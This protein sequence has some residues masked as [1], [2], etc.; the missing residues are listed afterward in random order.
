MYGSCDCKNIE[1]HWQ[2]VDLSLVPRACQCSY[3]APKDIAYVSKHHS[4]FEVTIHS[5]DNYRE[6]QQGSNLATF[7]ECTNCYQIV[8]VTADIDGTLHGALNA[9]TMENR[10]TFSE[11]V[12]TN[13][14]SLNRE[15]KLERWRQNWCSPVLVTKK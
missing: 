2:I 5:L 12:K 14:S 7:H 1:I 9:D 15:E 10:L 8:F 6:E 3:C 13:P 11:P 4:K